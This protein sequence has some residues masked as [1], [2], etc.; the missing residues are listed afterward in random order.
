VKPSRSKISLPLCLRWVESR[1]LCFRS[2]W[3]SRYYREEECIDGSTLT[4]DM[5]FAAGAEAVPRMK[6]P[7]LGPD[8]N[9]SLNPVSVHIRRKGGSTY[10]YIIWAAGIYTN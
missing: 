1:P 7:R 9:E 2:V 8:V 5:S 3:T 4:H 6:M 10:S